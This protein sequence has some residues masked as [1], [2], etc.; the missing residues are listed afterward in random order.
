MGAVEQHLR[1]DDDRINP[2]L[3]RRLALEFSI[4]DRRRV[5]SGKGDVTREPSRNIPANRRII[6]NL[7]KHRR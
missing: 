4:V 5:G 6:G 3:G 7:Q 1:L 2:V